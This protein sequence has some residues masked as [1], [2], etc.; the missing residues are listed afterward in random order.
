MFN[1]ASKK[2]SSVGSPVY[3]LLSVF[4]LC[5][6]LTGII[7]M[8]ASV[9]EITFSPVPLI[10]LSIGITAALYFSNLFSKPLF[11]AVLTAIVVFCISYIL[12]DRNSFAAQWQFLFSGMIP[13]AGESSGDI[14]HVALILTVFFTLLIFF[15]DILIRSHI[16]SFFITTAFILVPTLFGYSF[17][18]HALIFTILYQLAFFILP[19]SF[20]K[21]VSKSEK[22]QQ[23]IRVKSTLSGDLYEGAVGE[24]GLLGGGAASCRKRR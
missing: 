9:P 10:F 15:F 21:S 2:Q 20:K 18:A 1:G 23:R 12:A 19:L 14:G 3:H 22:L 24:V 4:F 5:L 7:L 11:Y 8:S 13:A 6:G 17:P 16:V